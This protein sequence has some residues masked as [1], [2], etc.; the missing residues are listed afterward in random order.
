[1][2][3]IMHPYKP[4]FRISKGRLKS[5]FRDPGG[6]FIGVNFLKSS[7]NN[8]IFRN[9]FVFHCKISDQIIELKIFA[10]Y[11]LD[12]TVY[13]VNTLHRCNFSKICFNFI[14]CEHIHFLYSKNNCPQLFRIKLY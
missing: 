11:E 8:Q 7:D 6:Q 4:A 9:D 2:N 14:V 5:A 3:N 13:S 10:P 1:M 12:N